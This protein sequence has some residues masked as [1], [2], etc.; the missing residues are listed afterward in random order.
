M[1]SPE[2]PFT[3]IIGG[4]KVKDKIDVIDNLLE[5]VDH[6]L[7]GGGLAFTFVKALGYEIGN[8]LLEEDKVKSAR[9]FIDKAEKNGVHLYLPKDVIVADAFTDDAATK[10][11]AIDAIPKGWLGLDIGP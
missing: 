5:K 11:V 7:I 3:S 6:L 2:R 10:T 4:A 8:S 1:G 9:S